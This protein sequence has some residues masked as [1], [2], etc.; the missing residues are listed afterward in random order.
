MVFAHLNITKKII[1]AFANLFGDIKTPVYDAT[2]VI[3]SSRV[4][5]IIYGSRSKAYDILNS[6]VLAT[7]LNPDS[8]AIK[9]ENSYPI[10]SITDVSISNDPSRQRVATKRMTKFGND[11]FIPTPVLISFTV[12]IRARMQDD[13]FSIVEQIVPH[14]TPSLNVNLKATGQA[15]FTESIQFNIDSVSTQIPTDVEGGEKVYYDATIPVTCKCHYY[16]L[17]LTGATAVTGKNGIR[18]TKI[19]EID[20]K[21]YVEVEQE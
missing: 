4:I 5:P 13:L 20:L 14:F 11:S 15:D 2:G 17:P 21:V 19:S 16:K 6:Q 12:N 3:T 10:M 1:L 7:D 9:I 8:R 18:T